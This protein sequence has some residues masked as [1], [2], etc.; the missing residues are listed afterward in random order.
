MSGVPLSKFR[1][2]A[3][4]LEGDEVHGEIEAA[5]VHAARHQLAVRGIRVTR[6]SER[7]GLQTEITPQQIPPV[8]I[9]HFCRQMATFIH[10]G[11]PLVEAVESLE[12]GARNRRFRASLGDVAERLRTGST[13][14][15]AIAAQGRVFP[16]YFAPVLRSAELTG[17]LDR[18]FEQLHAYVR[19]DIALTRTVR[20]ALIYPTILLLIAI[21]VV[22]IVVGL[23]IPRF[24]EFFES[25]DANLPLATRLLIRLA[26]FVVSPVGIAVELSLLMFVLGLIL[27]SR[28]IRGRRIIHALALRIPPLRRVISYS[29]TERFSRILGVMLDAGVP[30]TDALP[31]ATECIPNL[32]YRSK[33]REIQ[34]K[35]LLGSGFAEPMRDSGIFP[36]TMVQMVAVG[37]RTGALADQLENV[38]EFYEDELDDA[39]ESFSQ[40]FEP[41]VIALIGIVVG[42]VALAMVS[43][44]YG[45]YGQVSA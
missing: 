25:F 18:A 33:L 12:E 2:V 36:A 9:M 4:T 30:L 43:A 14:H 45:I 6:I 17:R 44:M 35:V 39:V 5:S 16:R 10:A 19:R 37:E 8:L 3:E 32:V 28:T 40:W 26:N 21:A 41:I 1:Y 31:A 23:V 20:K 22:A 7:K 13:V 42:F 34:E 15:E 29:S 27:F 24:A 11:V 38:A